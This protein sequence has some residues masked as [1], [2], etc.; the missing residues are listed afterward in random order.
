MGRVWSRLQD[1]SEDAT[2][3]FTRWIALPN[4]MRV[5]TNLLGTCVAVFVVSRWKG[6]STG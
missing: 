3:L 6:A 2:T 4:A 1:L 5:A